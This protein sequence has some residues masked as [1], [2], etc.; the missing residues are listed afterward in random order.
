[1]FKSKNASAVCAVPVPSRYA[2][3][4]RLQTVQVIHRRTKLTAQELIR[5]LF[6]ATSAAALIILRANSI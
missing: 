5:V 6:G 1:M 2:S 4:G 3:E